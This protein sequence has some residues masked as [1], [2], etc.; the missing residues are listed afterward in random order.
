MHRDNPYLPEPDCYC[1]M[2]PS[3]GAQPAVRTV[4]P[5]QMQHNPS[6]CSRLPELTAR[7]VEVACHLAYGESC[8]EIAKVLD[9]SIKT[10]DTHRAHVLRKLGCRNAVDLCRLAI[11]RGVV[12]P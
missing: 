12:L 2:Q 11:R 4:P 8:A 3:V 10:V 9:I 1:E 5:D 6:V 7:E